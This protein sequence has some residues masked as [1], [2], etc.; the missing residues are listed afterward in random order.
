MRIL[1]F[2]HVPF[3]NPGAILTWA[4]KRGHS[5]T[6]ARLYA[7]DEPPPPDAWDWLVV[8]G[9]PMSVHDEAEHPWLKAEKRCI[10]EAVRD[11]KTV[12]GVCLGAQLIAEVLG[13]E[14]FPNDRKEIGW[15]PVEWTDAALDM[16]HFATALRTSTVFHWHGETFSLPPGAKLLASSEACRNQAFVYGRSVFGFQFH[17]E[18]LE[19]N[20]RLMLENCGHEI[21]DGEPYIQSAEAM[22]QGARLHLEPAVAML[23]AFL[24]RLAESR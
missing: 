6:V 3:E 2:Q 17:M 1:F 21:V 15:F 12:V 5:C 20:L 18:M 11:G 4:E 16:P 8:M 10:A 19:D 13:G 14:V 7:G 24:D 23:N 22:R 9:G